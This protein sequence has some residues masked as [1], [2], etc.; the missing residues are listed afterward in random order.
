LGNIYVYDV[1]INHENPVSIAALKLTKLEHQAR[2]LTL[3]LCFLLIISTMT[4]CVLSALTD[5]ADIYLSGAIVQEAESIRPHVDGRWI[6]D[7]MG[8]VIRL[9]GAAVFWRFIYTT[10]YTQYDPLSYSDEVNEQSLDTLKT[11]GANF[12]R[13][14]VNGY[15]WHILKASKYIAAVDTVVKWCKARGIMVVLDNHAWYDDLTSTSREAEFVGEWQNFMVELAQKYKNESTVIGFDMWNEP[16]NDL[17]EST[18]YSMLPN[19]IS[20]IQTVDPSYLCFVEPY[21]SSSDSND[22]QYF[23]DHPLGFNNIVYCAHNYYAWDYPYAQYAI[24]YGNGD[25]SLAKEQMEQAYY[26]RW[27][28]M[29]QYHPVMNMESGIYRDSGRN[30]NW[31]VWENDSL[32][33]YEKYGVGICWFPFDPDRSG[34]SLISLLKS[35][36][37]GLTDAGTIWSSHMSIP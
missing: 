5:H 11:S 9:K 12:I 27:I 36:G 21:G 15:Y 8:N 13:L 34:S 16:Q 7:G 26:S 19:V 23:I 17:P 6:K 28:Y 14:S 33:L 1:L 37:F 22:M 32:T 3:V 2:I 18:Y 31:S 25:F 24:S 10:Q 29:S 35:D 20:A 4:T 30:P